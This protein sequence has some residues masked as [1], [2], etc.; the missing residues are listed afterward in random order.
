MNLREL[1]RGQDCQVR[2]PGCLYNSETVVLA[3]IRR[4]GTAGVGQKPPDLCGVYACAKC[5]DLMDGRNHAANLTRQEIDVAVLAGLCRTLAI[6][7]RAM[8]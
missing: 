4:G 2:L 3:H 6:V 7:S 8:A 1:A 5:H